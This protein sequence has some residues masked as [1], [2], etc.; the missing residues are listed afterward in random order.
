MGIQ[1]E[2][3]G[4]IVPTSNEAER[5]L[6]LRTANRRNAADDLYTVLR[7]VRDER[8]CPGS[9]LYKLVTE[10]LCRADTGK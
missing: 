1:M 8:L 2:N 7:M 4:K 3:D 10:V 5:K 9:A 6:S